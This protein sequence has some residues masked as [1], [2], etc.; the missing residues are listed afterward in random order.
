MVCTCCGS[1]FTFIN[2]LVLSIFPFPFI[3]AFLIP[4]IGINWFWLPVISVV[5]TW[6]LLQL[7]LLSTFLFSLFPFLSSFFFSFFE[8]GSCCCSSGWLQTHSSPATIKPMTIMGSLCPAHSPSLETVVLLALRL[9]FLCL[10]FF[11]SKPL[12]LYLALPW[13]PGFILSSSLLQSHW[14]FYFQLISNFFIRVT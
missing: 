13:L 11:P 7:T 4:V 3:T 14:I 8:T 6:V 1:F 12:V 9:F 5:L 2:P 10:F